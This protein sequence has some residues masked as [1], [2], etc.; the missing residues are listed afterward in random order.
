MQRREID[1]LTAVERI[2]AAVLRDGVAMTRPSLV[3]I[4]AAQ[5]RLAGISR[6]TPVLSSGDDRPARRTRG[7]AQGREPAAHRLVQ[8]PWRLQHDRAADRGGAAAG[9]VTASAG[10]HGQ[11]VAWAARQAGIA[12]TIFVPEGAPM[13]KVDAARGYGAIVTLG[14]EGFDDAVAAARAPRSRRRAR[15]SSTHSTTRA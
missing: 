5:E 15:H 13:A 7:L 3:D 12:A 10:N 6:V 11:A 9:V 4:V 2:V 14:G 1:P 8:D